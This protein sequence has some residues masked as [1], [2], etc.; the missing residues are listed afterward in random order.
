MSERRWRQ[1]QNLDPCWQF[2]EKDSS[3]RPRFTKAEGE[4]D[5]R[6]WRPLGCVWKGCLGP[7]DKVPSPT[8]TGWVPRVSDTPWHARIDSE[9]PKGPCRTFKDVDEAKLDVE[10]RVGP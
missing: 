10:Q 8:F 4:T 7:T 3:F 1:V 6:G 5:C 9:G 2:E